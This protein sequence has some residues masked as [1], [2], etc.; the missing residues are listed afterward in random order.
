MAKQLTKKTK[1]GKTYCRPPHV[2]ANIDGAIDQP[3]D[4]IRR[5]CEV[6]SDTDPA[7]LTPEC[8]VH[9]L[10]RALEDRDEG[11]Q[12]V[13]H[14]AL[15][16]RVDHTL[17]SK[18]LDRNGF[19]AEEVRLEVTSELNGLIVNSAESLDYYECRFHR[20]LRNLYVPK[21]RK[22]TELPTT[23]PDGQEEYGDRSVPTQEYAAFALDLAAALRALSMNEC[24]AFTLV[25]KLGYEVE[26]TDP[27]KTTAATILGV[28]GRMVRNHLKSAKT[29]LAALLKDYNS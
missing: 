24:E 13:L 9:L 1:E 23:L 28:S 18:I 5:R 14:D 26:S 7:F 6:A 16:R 20:A 2:E 15:M 27:K 22:V 4:V 8:I 12:G 25:E 3:L 10:R 19:D 29:T 11:R 17:R 21:V